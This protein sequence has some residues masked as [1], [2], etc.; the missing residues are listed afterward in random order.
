MQYVF[1]SVLKNWETPRAVWG[2]FRRCGVRGT[3]EHMKMCDR[4]LRRKETACK[5]AVLEILEYGGGLDEKR[6]FYVDTALPE[7]SVR[8]ARVARSA[9]TARAWMCAPQNTFSR[10]ALVCTRNGIVFPSCMFGG[11]LAALSW[12]LLGVSARTACA[13]S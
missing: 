5:Y 10:D 12:R 9:S 7:V 2:G 6:S 1:E 8:A 13:S 4:A 3:S 11:S